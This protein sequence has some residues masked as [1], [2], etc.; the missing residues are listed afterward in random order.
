MIPF[1]IIYESR[2]VICQKYT[3]REFYLTYCLLWLE[4]AKAYYYRPRM[5]LIIGTLGD[6][7]EKYIIY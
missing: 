4:K 5:T 1:G 2:D 7:S 3:V 6:L